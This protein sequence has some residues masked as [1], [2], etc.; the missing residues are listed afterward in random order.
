MAS[1]SLPS[2]ASVLG[3]QSL[4]RLRHRY[5]SRPRPVI[6]MY[7]RVARESFDPWGLAVTP[8]FFER[9]LAWLG[10]KRIVMPLSEFA[11]RHAKNCLPDRAVAL[12]FDDGYASCVT[13]ALPFL[14]RFNLPATVFLP[15]ELIEQQREFWWDE[16]AEIVLRLRAPMINFGSRQ[17]AVPNAHDGDGHW[18]PGS[19]PRTPRQ[20]LFQ[21]TWSQLR[22]LSPERLREAMGQLGSQCGVAVVGRESHRL[23]NEREIR[24]A[25][26]AGM[27]FGSHALTHPSLPRLSKEEQRREIV[28][29]V[30]R[31]A[32]LTGVRPQCFA[33]P[34]GHSDASTRKLVEEAGFVCACSTQGAFVTRLSSPYAFPRR[35]VGN[36]GGRRFT[37]MLGE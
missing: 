2:R 33:Y 14:R 21:E 8:D 22:V 29:S 16:L 36:F 30:E 23:L 32:Q 6:L 20:R 18:P 10:R 5:F 35:Q 12:T 24:L 3:A 7:H 31:C 9:Q 13:T 11:H 34:Y 4:R 1:A 25:E 26:S 27:E 28:E 17:L 19:A 15:V 37:A